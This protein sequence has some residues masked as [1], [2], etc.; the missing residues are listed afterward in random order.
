[1]SK[2]GGKIFMV[3]ATGQAKLCR[4]FLEEQGYKITT[5]F[6]QNPAIEKPFPCE[7]FHDPSELEYRARNCDGFIVCIGGSY[8]K[9]RAAYSERLQSWG[10][11]PISVKHPTAFLGKT[12]CTRKGL[13]MMPHAVANELATIGDW[14]ILNTNCTVDHECEIGNGV[15]IMGGASV[16]GLVRIEDFATIGTNATILPRLT[17]G[18]G[19]VVGAGAVVTRDVPAETVVVGVPARPL[20]K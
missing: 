10:I 9:A 18:T 20:D 12:T 17:I 11:E 19:A 14:C 2:R 8:G 13:Q 5:V 6:D 15:H 7:I 3:G 4:L 16:A 1:L